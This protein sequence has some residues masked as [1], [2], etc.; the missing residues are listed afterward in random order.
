MNFFGHAAVAVW[1]ETEPRFVLGS[2]L[3]DF[4]SML[5]LR[6]PR[7]EDAPLRRGIE[8]HHR[9]DAAFHG[10][11]EFI[12]LVRA[13]ERALADRGVRR[14]PTR[15][16]AHIG[17]EL[18]L[19][20]VLAGDSAARSAYLEALSV[21]PRAAAAITWNTAADPQRFSDLVRALERRGIV[22][23]PPPEHVAARLRRSLAPRPR[24]SLTD[25]EERV[26]CEWVPG[27]RTR[28]LDSAPQLLAELARRL[29]VSPDGMSRDGGTN[30]TPGQ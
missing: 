15:A 2:M 19:D 13:A 16:V 5:A 26:V 20:E 12:E 23:S 25:A 18:V 29:S 14:G 22:D 24:L 21:A 30:R 4:A 1:F 8:L 28:V 6:P 17:T 27:A 11:P 3:P 7:T 9:T 10:T